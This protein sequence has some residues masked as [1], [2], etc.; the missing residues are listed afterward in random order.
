[1][2]ILTK[3][4]WVCV[5]DKFEVIELFKLILEL[6]TGTT[7]QLSSRDAIVQ[8]IQRVLEGKICL[9]VLDD[10]WNENET[11]WD[12]FFDSLVGLHKWK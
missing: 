12:D 7:I 9:L 2:S 4:L 8:E 10:V 1:M 5:S 3:K 6:M 11:L